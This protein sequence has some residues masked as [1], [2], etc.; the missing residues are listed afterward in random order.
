M[1]K[2]LTY[3]IRR[4]LQTD[5]GRGRVPEPNDLYLAAFDDRTA[6]EEHAAALHRAAF[7]DCGP[8]LLGP[9]DETPLTHGLAEATSLPEFALRDFLLDD[10]IAPPDPVEP[11]DPGPCRSSGMSDHE[12]ALEKRRWGSWWGGLSR[13]RQ[14]EER[15]RWAEE[16]NRQVWE[17]WWREEVVGG[18]LTA[19]QR[20]RVC[21]AFNLLRLFE[22]VESSRVTHPTTTGAV[23]A[24]VHTR[25]VYADTWDFDSHDVA[26]VFPTRKAAEVELARRRRECEAGHDNGPPHADELTVV[27]LPF[28]RENGR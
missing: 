24:I 10:G 25:W 7:L 26:G 28:D 8:E 15:Q 17:R 19:A 20:L 4:R 6:A 3:L 2:T 14:Q 13:G 23:Y 18:R 11:A 12:W 5:C 9:D 27:E 1:I 21:E 16:R 22:V